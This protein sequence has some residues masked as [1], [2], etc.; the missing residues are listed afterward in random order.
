MVCGK[1]S[2]EQIAQYRRLA[3]ATATHI[4]GN[5]FTDSAG[6]REANAAFHLF[7]VEATGNPTLIDAHRRLMVTEYM[8]EVLTLST[9]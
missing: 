7:P 6:F 2:A 5:R 9:G 3:E 4:S 8:G 1:L